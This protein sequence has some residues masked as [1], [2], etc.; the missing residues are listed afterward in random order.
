MEL[1]AL[2]KFLLRRWWLI[3]LPPL[4]ALILVVPDVLAA[5]G[6]GTWTTSLRF[7]AAQTP[8]GDEPTYEDASFYPWLASEYVV[9]GLT[10]WVRTDSFA[11]E[12]SALLAADGVEIAPGAVRGAIAADNARSILVL[13]LTWPDA[14]QLQALAA[15]AT[16]A[17]QTRNQAYFPQFAASPADVVALDAIH[18]APVAPSL[19]SR[20]QPL[21]S[22][23]VALA[24]G[25]ALALLAEY[26]DDSLRTR[27]E[28]EMLG[29]PVLGEIPHRR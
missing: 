11:E 20:F 16:T 29:L 15:A 12:V 2:W 3:L 4:A 5:P 13:Y 1:I 24:A 18:L 19:L 27:Q 14:D 28:I 22:V 26:L 6:G 21:M 23:G 8:G 10:D 17:L 25:L 7:T 9:N